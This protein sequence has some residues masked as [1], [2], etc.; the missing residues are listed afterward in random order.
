MA[1]STHSRKS[2]F[3]SLMSREASYASIN[4][5]GNGCMTAEIECGSM[6][7]GSSH[8][9]AISGSRIN[10]MRSWIGRSGLFAG[11]VMIVK[12]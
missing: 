4:W 12:L 11:V 2:F 1:E 3:G 5:D 7:V 8:C 6:T 10:G 9:L